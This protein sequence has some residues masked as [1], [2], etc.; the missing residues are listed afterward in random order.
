MFTPLI[1]LV[2]LSSKYTLS[3]KI[4]NFDICNATSSNSYKLQEL[5]RQTAEEEVQYVR[6]TPPDVLAIPWDDKR[7]N[8]RVPLGELLTRYNTIKII[9]NDN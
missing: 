7:V 4:I 5:K 9:G 1:L 3:N 8:Q 2:I 6:G